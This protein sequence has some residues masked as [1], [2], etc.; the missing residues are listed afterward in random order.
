MSAGVAEAEAD[1]VIGGTV[2][3]GRIG[4]DGGGSYLDPSKML[5][6]ISPRL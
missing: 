3:S 4:P 5:R 2:N 6:Y 1:I